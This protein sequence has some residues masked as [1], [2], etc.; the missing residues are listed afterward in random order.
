MHTLLAFDVE[1]I[2]KCK[3]AIKQSIALSAKLRKELES[4]NVSRIQEYLKARA[5]LFEKKSVLLV[6]KGEIEQRISV[7]ELELATAL[8]DFERAQS[9]LE[10]Q[11]KQESITDLS[12]RAIVMLDKLRSIL[13]TKQLAKLEEHFRQE[14]KCLMRKSSFIDDIWIDEDF[15]IHIIRYENFERAKLLEMLGA[16][17]EAKLQATLG[18]GAWKELQKITESQSID[19]MLLALISDYKGEYKLPV[20]ID[21]GSLSNGEKQI[22]IMSLYYALVQLCPFEVPF[23][24]DTPFARIDSEHRQN[25]SEFFFSKLRGQVFILSTNEEI[26]ATHLQIIKPKVAAQYLLENVDN[27][28]TYV[29]KDS[30]FEE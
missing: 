21:K 19:Q 6:K 29:V 22:F 27:K 24:I 28:R 23:V 16:S 9:K 2:S 15:S 17:S 14:V 4:S 7:L 25:I 5:E 10:E 20:E 26:N 12:T 18:V 11:L 8:Q 3:K 30:Y 1:R 13:Y